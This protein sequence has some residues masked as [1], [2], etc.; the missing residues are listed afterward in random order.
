[1]RLSHGC[2]VVGASGFV[3]LSFE[4]LWARL[5]AVGSADSPAMFGLLLGW[6]L[7]GLGV[8]A[9]LSRKTCRERRAHRA[10]IAWLLAGACT[11]AL[12]VAP[13]MAWGAAHTSWAMALPVV[14]LAAGGLGAVLP[15]VAQASVPGDARTGQGLSWLLSSNILGSAIGSW[16]TGLYW[17]NIQGVAEIGA[18]LCAL[19]LAVS[20]GLLLPVFGAARVLPVGLLVVG[21]VGSYGARLGEGIWEQLAFRLEYKG[22]AFAR[23]QESRS[24]GVMIPDSGMGLGGGSTMATWTRTSWRIGT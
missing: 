15:L 11:V 23:V 14:A 7:L 19:G 24:G 8:G 4:I 5:G 6:Y 21:L 3:A 20:A 13:I 18:W 12:G 16:C 1:M 9:A 22:E 2:I 17:L 10:T